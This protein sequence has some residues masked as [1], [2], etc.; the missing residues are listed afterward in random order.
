VDAARARYGVE[1]H[2][3]GKGTAIDRAVEARQ[4]AQGFQFGGEPDA[5]ADPAVVERLLAQPVARQIEPALLPVP[6]RKGEHAGQLVERARNAPGAEAREH[7]LG[8]GMTAP[9]A[10]RLSRCAGPA[11][12]HGR[13]VEAV[14][15]FVVVVDFAV[16]DQD[17]ARVGRSHR[18][19]AGR[20]E[21]LDRQ[22][23]VSERQAAGRVF[24][25][26][27]VVRSTMANRLRGAQEGA[28]PV[29]QPTA[30]K[31]YQAA[32]DDSSFARFEKTRKSS[33]ETDSL[34]GTQF[35]E[36]RFIPAPDR[37]D[38]EILQYP[39]TGSSPECA[40]TRDREPKHAKPCL[41]QSTG[42]IGWNDCP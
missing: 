17:P 14:P 22:S 23:P 3:A 41:D 28:A 26:T 18:L 6:Q 5:L 30:E 35:F 16:E 27:G 19:V 37:A 11:L 42:T 36:D 25:E 7:G 9:A 20:R 34:G 40:T 8:I 33:A 4:R 38:F 2:H 21:I 12:P 1:A 29:D 31:P 13:L 32:H 10:A 15:Q 39:L 24:P